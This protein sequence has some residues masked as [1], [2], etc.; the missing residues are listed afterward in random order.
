MRE[1]FNLCGTKRQQKIW[2]IRPDFECLVEINY[3]VPDI[4]IKRPFKFQFC[5]NPFLLE[6]PDLVAICF[7]AF[8]CD[9]LH[10]SF[11]YRIV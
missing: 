3:F 1:I 10:K 7:Q 2:Y 8:T 11:I 6:V 9:H 5:L 4:D